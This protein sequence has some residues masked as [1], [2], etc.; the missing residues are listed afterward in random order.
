M[1]SRRRSPT[2]SKLAFVTSFPTWAVWTLGFF[3][4]VFTAAIA[5]LGHYLGVRAAREL[6]ARTRREENMRILRWAAELAVSNDAAKARLG[7]QELEALRASE[8]LTSAEQGFI[9][10]ALAATIEI[11]LQAIAQSA[12]DVE[13]VV[14][15]N[16][17]TSGEIPVSS[18]EGEQGE[19]TDI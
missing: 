3:L 1:M 6:E 12:R 9:Y 5:F 18:E 14:D 13:V 15:L 8:M 17:N 11:P 4:P 19:E 7:V 2:S 10:A 16:A